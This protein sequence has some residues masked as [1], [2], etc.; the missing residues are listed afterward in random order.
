[1]TPFNPDEATTDQITIIS[2]PEAGNA[3]ESQETRRRT[4]K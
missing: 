2:R 4:A 3:V 1:M